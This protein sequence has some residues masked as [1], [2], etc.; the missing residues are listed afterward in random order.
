MRPRTAAKTELSITSILFLM[1]EGI[2]MIATP[3]MHGRDFE[4]SQRWVEFLPHNAFEIVRRPLTEETANHL[5]EIM[6][7]RQ[8]GPDDLLCSYTPT[9]YKTRKHIIPMGR[10]AS[11][12]VRSQVVL[13]GKDKE[14]F[15]AKSL[16]WIWIDENPGLR[17]QE[18]CV[19]CQARFVLNWAKDFQQ[20]ALLQRVFENTPVLRPSWAY[21]KWHKEMANKP[22]RVSP[23]EKPSVQRPGN[24]TAQ[25][26]SV[27]PE[28]RQLELL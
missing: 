21:P 18:L 20:E 3:K 1:N 23:V 19:S 11:T 17:E 6:R 12:W 22:D 7:K 16:K 27:Q 4:I 10:L 28:S 9:K 2:D 24:S 13:A 25:E 5:I 8:V 15:S 26:F 14:L